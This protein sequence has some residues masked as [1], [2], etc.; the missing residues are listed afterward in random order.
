MESVITDMIILQPDIFFN[1]P[2]VQQMTNI[3]DTSTWTKYYKSNCKNCLAWCCRMPVEVYVS[4]LIRLG[5]LDEF[6]AQEPAKNLYKTL[7]KRKIV[8]HY[9]GKT[10][11]FT[12]TRLANGDCHFLN[13][14]TR[15]CTVYEN[16]PDTCRNHPQIG[17]RT[18]YCPYQ[19]KN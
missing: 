7:K 19:P 10:Q 6:E 8:E 11:K 13:Q 3:E 12:L 2:Q 18:G 14:L 1:T 5:V 9:V 16:R 4:D 15:G 17:P